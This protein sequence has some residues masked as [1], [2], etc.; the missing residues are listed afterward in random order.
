[1]IVKGIVLFGSIVYVSRKNY[2]VFTCSSTKLGQG[3]CATAILSQQLDFA[4]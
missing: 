4:L 3:L 1:M 2:P